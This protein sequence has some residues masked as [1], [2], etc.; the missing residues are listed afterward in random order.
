MIWREITTA[1]Q[2]FEV[3]LRISYARLPKF[4]DPY[5]KKFLILFDHT[6]KVGG[7]L[8]PLATCKG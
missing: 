5:P 6:Y 4:D 7:G 1:E 8:C 3:A 2:F